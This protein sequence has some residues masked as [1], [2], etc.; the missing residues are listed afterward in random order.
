MS[1]PLLAAAAV[2]TA[3]L[4]SGGAQAK[5][6]LAG[7]DICGANGC[8][9]LAFP[10]AESFWVR[11]HDA[12]PAPAPARFF[13]VRW[14]WTTDSPEQ[15]AYW[16]PAGA[17]VRWDNGADGVAW[18][19]LDAATNARL[20][21][22]TVSIEPFAL[23]LPTRVTIGGREV[24]AP[25]TYLKLFRGREVYSWPATPWLQIR[26]EAAAPSPWTDGRSSF[27]LARNKPYVIVDHWVYRIPKARSAQ[28]HRGAALR[29]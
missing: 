1:R 15:S 4:V 20:R 5:A 2:A 14:R 25:E 21:R 29:G 26:V 8:V 17:A 12:A 24:R 16:I 9:H 3:L 13:V 6:P 27:M 18:A 22:L 10:D 7:T 28:A 11:S 19:D 23:P